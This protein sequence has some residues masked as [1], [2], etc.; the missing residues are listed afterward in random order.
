MNIK[1]KSVLKRLLHE[2]DLT[3]AQLARATQIPPQTIN[4]WL[5]GLEPRNL[6]QVKAV[7][8]YFNVSM[9]AL[10]YG[11][12]DSSEKEPLKE[13]IDEINAGTFEVVLRRVKK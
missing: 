13:Y 7:A 11:S 6:N 8:N 10:V 1:L 4:N 2:R 12:K 9:D 5:S 3:S